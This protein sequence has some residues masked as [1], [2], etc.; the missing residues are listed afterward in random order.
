MG[1]AYTAKDKTVGAA[2]AAKDK[3]GD[4]AHAVSH[5]AHSLT[6]HSKDAGRDVSKC[7]HSLPLTLCSLHVCSSAPSPFAR[8]VVVGAWGVCLSA[9]DMQK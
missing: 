4:A 1:A 9:F 2:Y 3:A 5:K 6:H 7:A 8:H